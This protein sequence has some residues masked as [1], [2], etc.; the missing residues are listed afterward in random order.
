MQKTVDEFG[1]LQIVV[2]CAGIV[3]VGL[4]NEY[5]EEAWEQLMGGE[6][7]GHLSGRFLKTI[8]VPIWSISP[9][10]AVLLARLQLPPIRHRNM[11]RWG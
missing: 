5:G 2:N 4:L 1:A 7:E 11:R 9:R 6:R 8:G 3:H 10:L